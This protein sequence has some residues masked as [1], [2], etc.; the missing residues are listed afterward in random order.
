MPIVIAHLGHWYESA[1]FAVPMIVIA[2]VLWRSARREKL[3]TER[4]ENEWDGEDEWHDPRLTD[5]D[6]DSF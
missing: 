2:A 1:L 5:S 6:D 4:G 3:A